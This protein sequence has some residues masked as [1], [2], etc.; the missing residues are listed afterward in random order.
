VAKPDELRHTTDTMA[1]DLMAAA[2][3]L[4]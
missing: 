3:E 2:G 4:D 1:R